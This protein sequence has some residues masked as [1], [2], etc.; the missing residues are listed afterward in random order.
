MTHVKLFKVNETK[1]VEE[2]HF[3]DI[4]ELSIFVFS[5]F[6]DAINLSSPACLRFPARYFSFLLRS[7]IF[8]EQSD[9]IADTDL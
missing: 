2:E 6:N 9:K 4:G 8:K 3:N 1:L 7:E 5:S